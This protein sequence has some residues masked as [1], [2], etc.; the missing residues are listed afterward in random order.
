MKELTS[1]PS[2]EGE[3][4]LPALQISVDGNY[5]SNALYIALYRRNFEMAQLIHKIVEEQYE[6]PQPDTEKRYR[7]D[8]DDSDLETDDIQANFTIEGNEEQS[9]SLK[10]NVSPIVI[11]P[12]L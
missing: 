7:V 6:E 3:N 5:Q 10:C 1:G 8:E 4:R 9:G 11:L 12:W 2:G